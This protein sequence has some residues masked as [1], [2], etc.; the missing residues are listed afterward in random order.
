MGDESKTMKK[1]TFIPAITGE[2][3]YK[4]PIF[5]MPHIL[6]PYKVGILSYSASM[7]STFCGY[8]LDSIKTRMQ[9]HNYRNAFSCL[10]ATIYNEGVRGLFRGIVVPLVT[11]SFSRSFT[12]SVYTSC[13]PVIGGIVPDI[14]IEE[15]P[16]NVETQKFVQNFSVSFISAAIAGG[17]VSAFACPF[18]LTKIFQQIVMVVNKD[19]KVQ[20]S[21]NE[22]PKRV[23]DV[24]HSIVKY[25]GLRGL[26]SGYSYHLTRD[27]I[28][29]GLFYSIYETVKMK[30]QSINQKGTYFSESNK[31]RIDA[32]CVPLSGAVSGCIA[33]GSVYPL[34][35]IKANYQ[36]D[37]LGNIIRVKMGLEKIEIKPRKLTPS[38]D[39]YKGFGPSIVRSVGVTMIFFSAFEFLMGNIA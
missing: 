21:S 16:M 31:R 17:A 4:N 19:S 26:Y 11:T 6:Q 5:T 36:R 15:F 32:L 3:D 7:I 1:S 38:L 24:A 39:M 27:S 25:E 13:K 33:S 22:L 35:T 9:T 29:A 28:A 2:I 20:I 10:K 8:P 37:V 30:L 34:D 12:V 23:V 14:A 18:E